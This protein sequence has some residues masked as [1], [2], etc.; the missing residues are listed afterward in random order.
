ME[1]GHAVRAIEVGRLEFPLLRSREDLEHGV[2][3]E[4][5]RGAQSTIAWADHIIV[6]YPVWNG[7]M[8]ALFKGFLEQTFRPAFMFPEARPDQSLGFV[9]ALRQQKVLHGKT[10]RTIVTMQ[11]PAFVYRWLFHPHLEKNTLR[12]SGIRHDPGNSDRAGRITRWYEASMVA[13]QDARAG[14]GSAIAAARIR[15]RSATR[16]AEEQDMPG[17]HTSAPWSFQDDRH[18]RR[19]RRRGL[20]RI[21]RHHMVAIRRASAT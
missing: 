16:T 19:S 13:P 2:A 17:I 12:L 3:P 21:G 7:G 14:W 4:S 11:M 9:A 18:W 5:I 8:P 6:I 1:A 10:A 15:R 20:R